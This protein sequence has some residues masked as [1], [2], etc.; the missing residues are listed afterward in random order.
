MI[1]AIDGRPTEDASD[2]HQ[3]MTAETIGQSVI[4]TVIRQGRVREL[5]LFP[6]ELAV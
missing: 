5:T 1:I 4:A 6:E 2:L 3:A